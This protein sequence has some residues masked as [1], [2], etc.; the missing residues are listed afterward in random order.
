MGLT[1]TQKELYDYRD[2]ND[3]IDET[4]VN[5]FKQ[6]LEAE[7]NP[8]SLS[9]ALEKFI[10]QACPNC[11]TSGAY[12]WHFLGQLNHPGCGWS[13]YVGPGAYIVAQL[14]GVF[15]TGAEIGGDILVDSEKKGESGGCIGAMFGF[16]F[17]VCFR[18]PFALIMIPIQA[19]VSLA[20]T[21]P[22]SKS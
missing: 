6:R 15:R 14:K 11:G 19:I 10:S 16:I 3:F 2:K 8:N 13:W 20:Q 17:G 7:G 21:K 1:Q 18:L 22:Q 4:T 12:K 9:Y 5:S